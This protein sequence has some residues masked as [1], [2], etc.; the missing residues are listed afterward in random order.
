MYRHILLPTDGSPFA[1]E[2]VRHGIAL[3]KA[4]DARVTA[5][6]VSEPLVGLL[7]PG[8]PRPNPQMANEEIRAASRA[9]AQKLLTSV[10]AE[11]KVVGVACDGVHVYDRFPAAEGIL[12]VAASHACDLIVMG[13]HGLRGIR[14]ALL[15][16]QASEVVTRA[17]VSVLIV[18]P[19]DE[20]SPVAAPQ[21]PASYQHILIATDGSD[22]AQKAVE[23]GLA[24]AGRMAAR[25]SFVVVSE[26]FTG[27]SLA[28][29]QLSALTGTAEF[30]RASTSAANKIFRRAAEKAKEASVPHELIHVRDQVPSQAIVETAVQRQCDLI[31]MASHGRRGIQRLMLGSEAAEVLTRAP[32]PVLIAK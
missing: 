4:I 18:R 28:G 7:L 9:A 1:S 6:A 31:V 21:T 25:V 17:A 16:S 14:R 32:V 29:E 10:C 19:P 24:L 2:G 27:I 26:L 8:E 5:V 23:Q 3:A 15:G 30:E 13:S 22:L 20:A 12:E 11:A